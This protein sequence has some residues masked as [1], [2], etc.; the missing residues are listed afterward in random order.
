L[1]FPK[2]VSGR[3]RKGRKERDKDMEG[4]GDVSVEP[5]DPHGWSAEKVGTFARALGPA[6]QVSK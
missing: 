6:Q 5:Q 4:T 2:S 1:P 3:E